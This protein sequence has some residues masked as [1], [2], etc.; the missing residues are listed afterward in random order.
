MIAGHNCRTKQESRGDGW[1]MLGTWYENLNRVL[2]RSHWISDFTKDG[3]VGRVN[4]ADIWGSN[5]LGRGHSKVSAQRWGRTWGVALLLFLSFLPDWFLSLFQWFSFFYWLLV[6]L[7][8]VLTFFLIYTIQT[9]NF[10]PNTFLAGLRNLWNLIYSLWFL[11]KYFV[12]SMICI[13]F[14]NDLE[15]VMLNF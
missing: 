11:S 9:R 14:N 8:R 7:L 5:V 6:I 10:P 1:G 2:E 12:N 4:H 3:R 13:L 15:V